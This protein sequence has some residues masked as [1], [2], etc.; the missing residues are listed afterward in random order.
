MG[1]V[2]GRVQGRALVAVN[3]QAN[4]HANGHDTGVEH[5]LSFMHD[6]NPM[7]ERLLAGAPRLTYWRGK[8]VEE[9]TKDALIDALSLM[10]HK[11]ERERSEHVQHLKMIVS[12]PGYTRAHQAWL[13]RWLPQG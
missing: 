5:D 7:H 12:T 9:M 13:A 6:D 2:N 11:Y 3:G 4:W 10:A 1:E 8:S